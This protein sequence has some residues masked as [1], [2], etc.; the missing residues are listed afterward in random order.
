MSAGAGSVHAIELKGRMMLVSVLRLHTAD[1]EAL[2][3]ALGERMAEAP[4]LMHDM[5][6]VVDL[7]ALAA[8]PVADLLV[9][10]EQIR[11]QG[12]KLIGLQQS[13]AVPEGL[14]AASGL[15]LLVL[16]GRAAPEP[17]ARSRPAAE[18]RPE[19][20]QPVAAP[21]VHTPTR[22][23]T[24]HVRSGQ[25]IYA[26]GGD[27]IITGAVSAGAEILADGH[28]HIYGTLRGRA[29]A[30][31]RGLASATIF[32]RRLDAELVS[33]A[34]H[35]RIAEDILDSERGENRLVTLSG[36]TIDIAEI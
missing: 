32:C 35:Y 7:A 3:A 10:L 18:P 20:P 19:A 14:A 30:G 9:V 1:R 27:L 21:A 26:R 5:P 13:A 24:Q 17:V 4:D 36:E 34:G 15:P 12:F 6:V 22:V 29:L 33:I 16:G 11:R 31:V 25:Q 2:E 8:L 23:V 28:I